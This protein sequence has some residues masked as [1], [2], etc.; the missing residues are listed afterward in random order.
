MNNALLLGVTSIMHLATDRLII[1]IYII[2]VM[3]GGV[4]R[5]GRLALKK[6]GGGKLV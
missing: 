3:T 1:C 5:N 2:Q 6:V 4:A